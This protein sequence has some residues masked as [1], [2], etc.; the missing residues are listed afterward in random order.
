M[1]NV[2]HGNLTKFK[3]NHLVAV[4]HLQ[5]STHKWEKIVA[6]VFVE[7][8]KKPIVIDLQGQTYDEQSNSSQLASCSWGY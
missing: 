4:F 5:T 6:L 2:N 8:S 3:K 1:Y 7:I